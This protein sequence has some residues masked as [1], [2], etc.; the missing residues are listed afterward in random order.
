MSRGLNKV[1]LIGNLGKDPE[2]RNTSSGRSVTSFSVATN[3]TWKSAD[4]E[5]KSETDWFSIVAWGILA[6]RCKKKLLKGQQVYI[7]GRLQTRQ[8]EDK[9]GIKHK[10][11]EVVASDMIVLGDK[12]S[13]ITDQDNNP[14]ETKISENS[15]DDEEFPF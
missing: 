7:E 1:I 12:R 2:L 13:K 6:E 3:R 4:G 11:T 8:W 10:T 15:L 14:E 9:Q 5:Y